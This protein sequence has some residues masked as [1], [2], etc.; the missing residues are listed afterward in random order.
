MNQ[1][2]KILLTA[3]YGP[4]ELG[5]GEDMYD[6]VASRLGRGQGPFQVTSHCHYFAL[7]LIAENINFPTTVLENPHWEEFDWELDQGY[8]VVGFQLKSLHTAKIARMMKRIREKSPK[9]KIVVGGYGV[10]TLGS[11]VPGDLNGDAVYIRENADY[12]CRE[13]GVRFMRRILKDEPV[14][15]EITQYSLPTAGFSLAG[16]NVQARVP[17]ILVSLGCPNAC[18]FCNTSAFFYHKK[19]YVAEPEQ[20]Y[21]FAKNYQRRLNTDRLL[22]M[23]FDEDFFL[24]PDY[25]REL[26]RLIRSDRKTWGIKYF[27]FGGV[28]SLSQFEAEELRDNGLGAVWIGVESFLCGDQLTDDRYGKRKGKEINDLFENLHRNGIQTVGSLVLGFDFHTRENLKEDIDR[29]V[30]LKPMSYQ[31]S[32]LTPCPGTALYDRLSEEGR[33]LQSYGWQDFHLWKDD[34]FELNHFEKGEIKK[35]FDY[36]HEQLRDVNGPQALQI[37]ESALNCYRLL[38]DGS[39]EFHRFQAGLA[40]GRAM[41][42]SAYLPAVKLHHASEKVRKRAETLEK[43]LFEEIGEPPLLSKLISHFL[44]HK[45]RQNKKKLRPP[46][47]SDPEPRWTYYHT[48]DDRV[49]VRKGRTTSKPVPYT[50]RRYGPLSIL[51]VLRRPEVG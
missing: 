12:L 30:A 13:E 5:W 11:P 36:A 50:D 31:I 44:S 6:L 49:W 3:S 9:T 48:L 10:S 32:P 35:F 2:A 8:E 42:L 1:S 23:L 24:N 22:V 47:V 21:R 46:V 16:L 29:F 19:I 51:K 34:V 18:D 43:R 33:I 41:G 26:G 7:Y 28:R 27:T 15:R 45:I 17:M 25:V 20:V 40:K 39:D 37:M 4:N 38:K 14:D